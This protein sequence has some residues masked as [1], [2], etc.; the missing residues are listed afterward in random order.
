MRIPDCGPFGETFLEANALAIVGAFFVNSP[1]GGCVESVLTWLTHLF[2][3]LLRLIMKK[4]HLPALRLV[5]RS[6][7]SDGNADRFCSRRVASSPLSQITTIASAA[8]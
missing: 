1:L 6:R 3:F 8:Q 5:E 4:I 2:F 7:A